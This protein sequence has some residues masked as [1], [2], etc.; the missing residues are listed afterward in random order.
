MFQTVEQRERFSLSD[1]TTLYACC[2]RKD[3]ETIKYIRLFNNVFLLRSQMVGT[4]AKVM[5]H[6][7]A[8]MLKAI[9]RIGY[10]GIGMMVK[11]TWNFRPEKNLFNGARGILRDIVYAGSGYSTNEC[12]IALVEFPDYTGP[13]I[14]EGMALAG[15]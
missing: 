1:S 10:L 8:G 6:P 3:V 13:L 4:H 5:N 12:P 15:K 11:L 14:S 9:P 2:S 7:K